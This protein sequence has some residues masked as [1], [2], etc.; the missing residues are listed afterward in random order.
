MKVQAAYSPEG[1][2]IIG[3]FEHVEA[4]ANA[5]VTRNPDGSPNVQYEGSTKILWDSQRTQRDENDEWL[6]IDDEGN[7]CTAAELQWREE[8]HL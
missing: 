2:P 7:T 6:Y 3:T 4:I 1:H 8:I 5:L